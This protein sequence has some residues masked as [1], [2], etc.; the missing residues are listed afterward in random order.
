MITT[1]KT[2]SQQQKFVADCGERM[3]KNDDKLAY[4]GVL[5]WI[6]TFDHID[7]GISH[8]CSNTCDSMH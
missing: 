5:P 1:H 8:H 6:Y 2:S 3:Q 4:F 7:V